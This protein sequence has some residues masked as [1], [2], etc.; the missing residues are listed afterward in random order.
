ME[1]TCVGVNNYIENL[2][3]IAILITVVL[4]FVG[5]VADKIARKL[6]CHPPIAKYDSIEGVARAL[7]F[8]AHG[9]RKLLAEK[10]PADNA[11]QLNQ[12]TIELITLMA[13]ATLSPKPF[14]DEK[15]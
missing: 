15:Q 4:P 13:K 3:V 10:H 5:R 1:T 14:K 2:T 12:K 8:S 9:A 11:E 7:S 6:F